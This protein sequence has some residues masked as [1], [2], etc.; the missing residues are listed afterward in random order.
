MMTMVVID[1]GDTMHDIRDDVRLVRDE[2]EK[3][4][5]AGWPVLLAHRDQGKRP[6]GGPHAIIESVADLHAACD[7]A[8]ITGRPLNFGL[9]L[10]GA[11]LM[12][13]DV[14]TVEARDE[15]IRMC[16]DH[17]FADDL[18]ITVDSPGSIA[19][20]HEGG[21]HVWVIIPQHL[22]G[23]WQENLP[24]TWTH[25]EYEGVDF[26]IRSTWVLAPPSRREPDGPY[27]ATGEAPCEMPSW[28]HRML[29]D[30]AE[31]RIEKRRR[32]AI[33]SNSEVNAGID[34]FERRT[35]W[36]DILPAVGFHPS[37]GRPDSCGCEVYT[38]E[39][40]EHARSAIAHDD[41]CSLRTGH[42]IHVFSTDTSTILGAYLRDHGTSTASKLQVYALGH[43]HGH[44][45]RALDKLGLI[46][47]DRRLSVADANVMLAGALKRA[48]IN[49]SG[50]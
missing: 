6:I 26:K 30:A 4:M 21:G 17:G 37:G 35:D 10:T 23:P 44:I 39:G 18:P 15:L 8:E 41:G 19:Q 16:E 1:G 31:N 27:V 14:D 47:G 33:K 50:L 40:A 20:G 29:C 9:A 25:P 48:G 2:A 43:T 22:Q 34:D 36:A 12:V 11:G 38:R 5:H 3:F 49:H 13:I 42:R 46:D 28:L 7:R 32:R 45:G 24:A